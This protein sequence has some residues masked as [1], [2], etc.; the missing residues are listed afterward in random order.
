MTIFCDG[1]QVLAAAHL[2]I[3]PEWRGPYPACG[4][5]RARVQDLLL[6]LRPLAFLG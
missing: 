2:E 6:N 1:E 3:T 4:A 5:G